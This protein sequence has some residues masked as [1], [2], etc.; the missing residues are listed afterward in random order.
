MRATEDRTRVGNR[1]LFAP[2]ALLRLAR[3][4]R[5]KNDAAPALVTPRALQEPR[6][7]SAL[8]LYGPRTLVAQEARFGKDGAH[9]PALR[10]PPPRASRPGVAAPRR[11]RSA[12]PAPRARRLRATLGFSHATPTRRAVSDADARGPAAQ[13]PALGAREPP[14]GPPRPPRAASP[15]SARRPR[16]EAARPGSTRA[17]P[18][19]ASI[20]FSPAPA[21]PPPRTLLPPRTPSPR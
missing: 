13:T 8:A 16:A 5:Q 7:A 2:R 9:P 4:G 15:P 1:A 18:S 3:G 12:S 14:A 17:T 11:R 20:L 10:P 6:R 21:H 19:S